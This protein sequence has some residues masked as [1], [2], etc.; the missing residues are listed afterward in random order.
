MKKTMVGVPP[1]GGFEC[2][3]NVSVEITCHSFLVACYLQNANYTERTVQ[4]PQLT[5][6]LR[7]LAYSRH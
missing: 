3:S 4:L 7:F 2:G 5:V 6:M 1:F